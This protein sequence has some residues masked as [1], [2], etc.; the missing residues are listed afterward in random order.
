MKKL[1][2]VF[3]VLIGLSLTLGCSSTKEG[4]TGNAADMSS[5]A[6]NKYLLQYN[7]KVGV[8]G[9]MVVTMDM[10]IAME[11]MGQ[12]MN[13]TQ[14]IEMASKMTVKENS[15]ESVKTALTYEYFAINMDIPMMGKMGYD[16]RKNDN[17]GMLAESLGAVFSELMKEEMI[18]VQD[19]TGKTTSI[20]GMESLADLQQGS[21]SFSLNSL[22]SF[23]QFPAK[24]LKVGDTWTAVLEDK[25]NPM[26]FD[27]TY[28][29][30][31]ITGGKVYID[32]TADVTTNSKF[33][34]SAEESGAA[35]V[36]GKQTGTMI[37]Q[38]GTMWLMEG[39][40]KQD[41]T[42]VA[43]QMGMEIPMVMKTNILMSVE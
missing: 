17:E 30:K 4:K 5:A 34:G 33:E 43:N 29:L 13:T 19:H 38:E 9:K 6:A 22:V 10:D 23:S 42:M 27:V 39:M 36:T 11:V 32:L 35:N 21:G 16:T 18:L 28:T 20:E 1:N 37:Y 31:Q 7:P 3:I 40:M 41:F 8:S 26:K 2:I 12:S 15:A 25:N 14:T 24:A